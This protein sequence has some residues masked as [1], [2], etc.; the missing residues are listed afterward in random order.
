[1]HLLFI[2]SGLVLSV[3]MLIKGGLHFYLD[4]LNGY[5]KTISRARGFEYLLPYDKRVDKLYENK[6]KIC[7]MAQKVLVVSTFSTI[8]FC[9]LLNFTKV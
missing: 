4:D 7:N 2:I 5:E 1:M 6:K 3:S 9:L 8:L